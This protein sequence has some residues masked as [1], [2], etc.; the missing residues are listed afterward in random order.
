MGPKHAAVWLSVTVYIVA[1]TFINASSIVAFLVEASSC[2]KTSDFSA[3]A[4]TL[5]WDDC[6]VV[7]LDPQ[8][9]PGLDLPLNQQ[10]YGLYHYICYT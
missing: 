6:E 7:W 1:I 9:S 2:S 5:L 10:L 4:P 3:V 8:A